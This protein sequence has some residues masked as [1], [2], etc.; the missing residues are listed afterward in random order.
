MTHGDVVRDYSTA[1]LTALAEVAGGT[2]F[3]GTGEHTFASPEVREAAERALVARGTIRGVDGEGRAHLDPVEARLVNISMR[4]ETVISVEHRDA[5]GTGRMLLYITADG[6]VAHHASDSGIHRL[7]SV[8]PSLVG[9]TVGRFTGIEE[10]TPAPDAP[11]AVDR[12]TF[13]RL[14]GRRTRVTSTPGT[15][16]ATRSASRKLLA[17]VRSSSLVQA[18]PRERSAED[19]LA[20]LDCGDRG[21]WRTREEGGEVVA[22]PV[23]VEELSAQ[24]DSLVAPEGAAPEVS[25]KLPTVR[26]RMHFSP[27]SSAR[28]RRSA[29]PASRHGAGSQ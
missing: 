5:A 22:E 27:G 25:L 3:P 19:P 2:S 16:M 23:T 18:V 9:A 28:G 7:E 14:R 29:G 24:F 4:P 11:I 12:T 26:K 15:R 21:L 17:A 13:D 20:W 8:P 6:A 1:E 10:R